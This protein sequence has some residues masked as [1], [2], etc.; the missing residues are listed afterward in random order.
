MGHLSFSK[1]QGVC[2]ACSGASGSGKSTQQ[3]TLYLLDEPTT[4]LHSLE[5][6]SQSD[7]II[8]IEDEGGISRYIVVA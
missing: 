4:R 2:P 5:I 8:D 7:Y 3:H 6:I 1:P